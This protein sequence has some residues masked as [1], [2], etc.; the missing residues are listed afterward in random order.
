MTWN[1]GF[2]VGNCYYSFIVWL[3]VWQCVYNKMCKLVYTLKKMWWKN[4]EYPFHES[5]I[6]KGIQSLSN[7]WDSQDV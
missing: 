2:Q 3:S 7:H 1:Y 4:L 6:C 5:F